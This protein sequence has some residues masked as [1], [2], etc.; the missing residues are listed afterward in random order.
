M[1]LY[2]LHFWMKVCPHCKAEVVRRSRRSSWE[3]RLMLHTYRC[4]VCDQRWYRL[5]DLPALQTTNEQL[6]TSYD[7]DRR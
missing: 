7:S 2:F 4:E 1:F 3:R 6:R 5:S